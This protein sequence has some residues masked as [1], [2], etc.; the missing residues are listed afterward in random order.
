MSEPYPA[1]RIIRLV[2]H[3]TDYALGNYVL[4]LGTWADGIFTPFATATN[5]TSIDAGTFASVTLT[6][7]AP[8]GALGDLAIVLGSGGSI[9]GQ[10]LW[11]NVQLTSSVPEA[12]TWVM[13]LIGFAGIGWLAYRRSRPRT[14]AF[15][16]S[17][18]STENNELEFKRG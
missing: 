17:A 4:M 3:R 10:A 6:G 12:S 9:Q 2:G 14:V 18:L 8:G 11:D 5:P 7:K 13:M 15:R 16:P 1:A